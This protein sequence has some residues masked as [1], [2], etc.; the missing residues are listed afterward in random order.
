MEGHRASTDVKAK[1]LL[2][3][4][5]RALRRGPTLPRACTTRLDARR[6][7]CGPFEVLVAE[8]A[9]LAREALARL[10]H[11]RSGGDHERETAGRTHRDPAI[12]VIGKG[13]VG[14]TLQVCERRQHEA[15][16]HGGAARERQRFEQ[17]LHDANDSR[18]VAP[19]AAA[20]DPPMT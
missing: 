7:T 1:R 19:A 20:P 3:H 10:L 11:M 6:E 8:H 12:F 13:A 5:S 16:I 2:R 4:D 15:V 9:D 18:P 17:L 14:M